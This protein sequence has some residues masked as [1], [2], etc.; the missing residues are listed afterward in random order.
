MDAILLNW[1]FENFPLVMI[2]PMVVLVEVRSVSPVKSL[3]AEAVQ[4]LAGIAEM[5]SF[6]IQKTCNFLPGF[7]IEN[8]TQGV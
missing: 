7:R 1:A 8:I 3:L 6:R 4:F 2:A 5:F